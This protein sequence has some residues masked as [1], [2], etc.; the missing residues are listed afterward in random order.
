MTRFQQAF[1]AEGRK[2]VTTNTWWILLVVMGIYVGFVGVFLGVILGATAGDAPG[3]FAASPEIA[4]MVYATAGAIGFVF[5]VLL[6][7]LAVTS[8]YRYRTI[9][10]T[11]LTVADRGRALA[12]KLGVQF[13]WGALFGVVAYAVAILTAGTALAVG[14]LNAG[15]GSGETWLILLRAVV[16]MGLWAAIGVGLGTLIHSQAV[17]IVVVLVFTQFIE[18]ILRSASAIYPWLTPVAKFLPGAA[19]DAMAGRSFYSVL[20][21]A[22]GLTADTSGMLPWWGGSLVMLAYATIT[23]GIGYWT[24]WRQDVA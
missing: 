11:F 3:S 14:G 10:P 8:E 7:A 4:Q 5:P 2:V 13:L 17:V 9:V 19:G 6:G 16:A 23:I 21:S 22:D 24:R 18:P 12:A 1:R 20:T 15:L